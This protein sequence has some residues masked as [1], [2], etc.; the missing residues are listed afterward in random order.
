MDLVRSQSGFPNLF[1]IIESSN[2]TLNYLNNTNVLNATVEW[3]TLFVTR[4][5]FKN[6]LIHH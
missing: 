3:S 1:Q 5:I 2:F 4:Y 6:W